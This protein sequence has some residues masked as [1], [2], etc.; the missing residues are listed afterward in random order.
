[1]RNFILKNARTFKG[2]NYKF[3][4]GNCS[5][6][7][8]KENGKGLGMTGAWNLLFRAGAYPQIID[9][10]FSAPE[11]EDVLYVTADE[12]FSS[13]TEKALQDWMKAGGKV[14][15]SGC[16]EAWRFVFPDNTFVEGARLDNPYAA[17][18]WIKNDA[19]PELIAPPKWTYLRIKTNGDDSIQCQ[20][21]LAAISG[22]R[23][24]PE[25]A[26]IKPL[27]NAPAILNVKNFYFLN[28]NPFA[29]FQAWIQGQEDLTPWLA[30]RHRIFWL[31]EFTVFLCKTLRKYLLLPD[32]T[33][34]I[35]G[36][37][38]TTVVLKHDL[39]FSR[40]TT[41]LE[42]ENQAGIS[43][44]YPILKDSNTK[45]WVNMLK[46]F[47]EHETAFHYNT[48]Q[49]SRVIEALR[50]RFLGFPKRSYSP[51]RNA[52]KANGLFKQVRWAIENGVG[53]ETLHRHLHFIIYPELIDAFDTV[54]RKEKNVLGGNSFFSSIT[55]RWGINTVSGTG[56]TISD[57]TDPLFP[58]WFPFRMAHA[59][60]GGRMLRGW[61][62]TSLMEVEPALMQQMLDYNIPEL[63]QKVIVLNYHPAHATKSTFVKGGCVKWFREI[64][65]LCNTK[66]VEVRS[67]ADIYKTLNQYLKNFPTR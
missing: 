21:K 5:V 40:N 45:F 6:R 12:T 16:P 31:D 30:W 55:L 22:E 14:L 34:S 2:L 24:T 23:L 27:E 59:G 39:D 41:Y 9:D 67:L 66:N 43:G 64:F 63:S 52:I 26:L 15:A 37:A 1:M 47:P 8:P 48:G 10:D 44:V 49:Y 57:F 3:T 54:Y 19:K 65:E 20:G 11:K 4:G 29:A 53:I 7:W 61:E 13:K 28:G 62:T 56:G 25:R 17:L 51:D 33:K 18:A 50:S 42:M 38:K 60:D 35:P 36:L 32:K 46:A 58:Y